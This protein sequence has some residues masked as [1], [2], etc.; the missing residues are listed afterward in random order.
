M[1]LWESFKIA[2]RS[3]SGNK[4]RSALT[5]LGIVIGVASVVTMV[6]VGSGAQ[7]QVAEQIRSLG[8]NVL[9]VL[10]GA[11][12]EGAARQGSG[13]GHTLT[14]GDAEAIGNRLPTVEAAAPAVRGTVQLIAGNQNWNTKVNGTTAR[15]FLIREWGLSAGR[16]FS[17]GEQQ[18][19]GK[20]AV[21]GRTVAEQ[22]FTKEDPV[23]R[24]IRILRVPFEVIGILSE[25]GPSGTG[26]NQ[27]DIVFIPISTAK[28]RL[29]GSAHQ[30]NRDAVNY[31]L[32]KAAGSDAIKTAERQIVELLR[33]RHRLQPG[34][35]EDF[36][37]TNPAA[38]M[39][40]QRSSTRTFAWLLATIASVS[41]VVGGISIMN[42]MLVSV[43]ERTREIGLRRAVGARRRDIRNQFL[44]E[45]FT[46]C[47]IG[48]L[49]GILAG[50]STSFAVAR[51]VGW[52]VFLSPDAMLIALAFAAA[53]G[54]FF[55]YYPASRAARMD[56]IESLR[57]E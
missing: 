31:V 47:L 4:M 2:L 5:M 34:E 15:Y 32:V 46:L 27:D 50:I 49:I 22:L 36:R 55:G 6:A 9:M 35:P 26:R 10:P 25:K 40:A 12:R 19:A 51:I 48:G 30:V 38:A 39:A 57:A 1:S 53:V 20:V 11:A 3:L 29:I 28:L 7:T 43:T 42:I 8:A 54:V 44:I 17:A 41:L 37:V 18:G 13:T 52:P 23:G 56:P 24:T 33:R 16:F 14:E 21:I 45:S